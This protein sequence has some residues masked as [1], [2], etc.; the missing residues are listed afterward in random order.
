MVAAEIVAV[1]LLGGLVGLLLAARFDPQGQAGIDWLAM[2]AGALM[3][4]GADR[5]LR[6]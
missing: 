2:I 1:G 5:T 4:I 3:A 6:K